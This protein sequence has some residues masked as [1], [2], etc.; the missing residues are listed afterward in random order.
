MQLDLLKQFDDDVKDHILGEKAINLLNL[1]NDGK[2]KDLFQPKSYTQI[3]QY[4][5]LIAENKDY[6]MVGNI[7]D[8]DGNIPNGFCVNWRNLSIIKEELKTNI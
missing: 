7:L 4:I 2:K 8:L 3:N 1:L 5:V 6:G